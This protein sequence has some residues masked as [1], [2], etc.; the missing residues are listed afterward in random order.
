ML[1]ET[2][3]FYLLLAATMVAA[4]F[5]SLVGAAVVLLGAGSGVLGSTVNPF[6]V[7]AATSALVDSGVVVNNGIIII[8]GI[9]LWLSSYAISVFFVMRYARKVKADKGS[10]I[11][12]LQEQES[13]KESFVDKEIVADDTLTKNQKFVLVL[14]AM[15]FVIMII[16]FIPWAD[17]GVSFFEGWSNH[18]TGSDIGT[19]YFAECQS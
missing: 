10:T 12:S 9:I 7:G 4:G 13:M 19:W 1:E 6:A 3:P 17:L 18:L 8:L 16:A 11:L 15:T 14:F 5:D 2:T